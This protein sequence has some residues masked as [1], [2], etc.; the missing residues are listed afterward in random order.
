MP[1]LPKAFGRR[2]STNALEEPFAEI[3]LNQQTFKVFERRDT[4]SKS[5][6]AGG[7]FR[8]GRPSIDPEKDDNIFSGFSNRGSD[9]SNTNT[10]STTDNS[11]RLSAVSTASS[12]D[13][14]AHPDH[15]PHK[16]TGTP[17][18]K[19]SSKFSLK[20]TGKA[21]SFGRK[22]S[23]STSSPDRPSAEHQKPATPMKD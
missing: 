7:K 6:D 4:G 12:S 11:S 14:P 5:I 10:I 21:F 13:P 9:G 18:V 23:G 2:K 19:T 1:K 15:H 22:H 3:P 17:V 16:N 20:N 8:P